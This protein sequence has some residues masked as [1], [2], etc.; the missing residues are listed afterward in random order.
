MD[1]NDIDYLIYYPHG[2]TGSFESGIGSFESG[3]GS[4][5]P[6]T[7]SF[8]SGIGPVWKNMSLHIN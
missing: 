2:Y 8:E 5:Q 3:N 1:M 7:G 6:E 4:F